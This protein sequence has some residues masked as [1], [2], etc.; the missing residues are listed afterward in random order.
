MGNQFS[1]LK[2]QTKWS[3]S[4]TG[5]KVISFKI[6]SIGAEKFWYIACNVIV[7]GTLSSTDRSQYYLQNLISLHF[8]HQ[9]CTKRE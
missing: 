4:I 7:M 1:L 8:F 3:V 6:T 9:I 2:L 5:L